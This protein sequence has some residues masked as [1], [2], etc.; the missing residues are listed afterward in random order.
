MKTRLP[1]IFVLIA[2][3]AT[4]VM[5]QAPQKINYQAIVRTASG[6]T[7]AGGTTVS[8]RFEIHNLSPTGSVVYQETSSAITNQFGLITYAIGSGGN[9]ATVN[10]GNGAKY[11]DVA[12]DP[13]GGNN[14]T[15]MGSSELLSVPY[16]L[17][18]GNSA[19]GATGAT[20]AQGI[21]GAQGM[22]GPI[23]VSGPTGAQGVQGIQG[24][25]GNTGTQGI[26]GNTGVAG[27]TGLQGVQGA[28]GP[29]G[30]QG[31]QGNQGFA[32]ATGAQGIQGVQGLAGP[33]GAQGSQGV[34]GVDGPTGLQGS[35]GVQ[36]DVGPTGAQGSQGV[37]GDAGTTGA[38]G[39]QGVQGVQGIDGATGAQGSQGVQGDAGTTGAPGIQGVQG[40]QGID[41]ATGAQGSQGVQGDVGPTGAQGSQGV[42]GE[43]GSTGAQG[44][45]GVQGVQG[46]AGSTG[47][48]GSQ[49]VQGDVGPTGAQGIQG[50]QG[51]QG[52]DGPTGAQ[53]NQGVQGDVGPT[54]AQGIQGVQGL[55]GLAGS[56]GAQG[57][58]GVQGDAGPTG[59]QGIQGVQG[60]DGPT[61]AQ[62]SQ[63]VQGDAGTTGAQGIQGVQGTDG[64]TGAQ[65]NQGVQGDVGLTGAQGI[66]GVQG[67]DGA[68][69]AQGS[70]GVQGN[71][72]P[73]GAQGIQGVAGG[74]GAQGV[75]G[76]TGAAGSTGFLQA[77]VTGSMPYYNGTSWITTATNVY[78]DGGNIGIGTTAP[79]EAQLVVTSGTG[80][81]A[82]NDIALLGS[83]DAGEEHYINFADYIGDIGSM[84]VGW[85]GSY[86]YMDFGNLYSG[87]HVTGKPAMTIL[88]NA[89]NSGNVGIG[90]TT[91]GQMLTVVDAGNSNTYSGTLSVYA[92][93]L[94]QG[95]GIGYQ[96]ISALGSN[97]N[98]DLAL[99]SLGTG[100]ITMQLNNSTGNVGIGTEPGNN[101]LYVNQLA[102]GAGTSY[103]TG[104]VSAIYGQGADNTGAY[105]FGI[106]GYDIGITDRSGGV[107]GAYSSIVWGILGYMSSGGTA[108]GEYSTSSTTGTGFLP[109]GNKAAGVG[110]G[111]LGDFVGGW[112]RGG[113][114]GHIAAGELAAGYNM[115]NVYTSGQ[116]IEL[117]N[118]GNKKVAA[119]SNTSTQATV[120]S[121]GSA[122]LN[123][124]K[125]TVSFDKEFAAL[126]AKDETPVVTITPVG[127]CN[128]VHLVNIS[129]SG[130]EVEENNGGNASVKFNYMV[131]GK[132]I[133]AGTVD[134]PADFIN[135]DFDKN[136]K[137]FMYNEA[138]MEHS[139]TPV[140]W[141][142]NRFRFEAVPAELK[143]AKPAP[144]KPEQKK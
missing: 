82:H 42:Q 104:S 81:G 98:Q 14:F 89:T 118:T 7:V 5:A 66:Q 1:G 59:A 15:D 84:W 107:Q 108:Y 16:A 34:Q 55:Q 30:A 106:T 20:G 19:V 102:G 67:I 10:W 70:Q 140:W 36:G 115:G 45:Q 11:L 142:G 77:G 128:G 40:V 38:P 43:A 47:A 57:S 61:G 101:R 18:S 95:V 92:N 79:T 13:A 86:G 63:G 113:I 123:N 48:Q 54:G 93:N 114:V 71:T 25:A 2:V 21:T 97:T 37:Q 100:N 74:T 51:V 103:A 120:S 109:Q 138:D 85:T 139:A 135:N 91:P 12:I 117:V 130:F 33:T 116:Q 22:Q 111:S 29:T 110:Q 99:N 58:Q 121:A 87:G 144:A 31:N 9:L 131:M 41:G 75:A 35:Q 46:L 141:D 39:I 68:T 3:F 64:T 80:T 52:I 69:G 44:I 23:G 132:R 105:T 119:F 4:S 60:I 127:N 28:V 65:G 26:Q 134:V 129:A 50:V 94:T 27:P 122:Q 88:G 49:G 124:G 76:P 112:A 78:N 126:L 133:D 32:G 136:L 83:F 24:V 53:G 56:T 62:G 73:S 17:Y 8:L 72:G 137:G 125:A 143:P 6:A 90:T 96:G